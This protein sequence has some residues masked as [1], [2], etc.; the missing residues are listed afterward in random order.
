M[1]LERFESGKQRIVGADTVCCVQPA[2]IVLRTL[3]VRPANRGYGA[4]AIAATAT[5]SVNGRPCGICNRTVAVMSRSQAARMRM[6]CRNRFAE[7]DKSSQQRE[8][9]EQVGGQA[10]H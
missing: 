2:K 10:L 7:R 3:R 6:L 9:Q 5:R 1:K 8:K 4:M